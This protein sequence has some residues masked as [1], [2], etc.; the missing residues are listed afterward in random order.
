MNPSHE[1]RQ[2]LKA[3]NNFSKNLRVTIAV[4]SISATMALSPFA[5]A[6][7]F[8]EITLYK[9]KMNGR[10]IKNVLKT[11]QVLVSRQR[12]ELD[13]PH[14]QMQLMLLEG[15]DKKRLSMARQKQDAFC[16]ATR[17]CSS[18]RARSGY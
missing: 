8:L 11:S 17:S 15:Q 16:K 9:A 3:K 10:E 2:A 1:S 5:V 12:L 7:P 6:K 18:N 13:F 14:V 4:F